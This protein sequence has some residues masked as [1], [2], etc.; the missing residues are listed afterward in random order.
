MW[1]E[2]IE[3]RKSIKSSSQYIVNLKWLPA[4]PEMVSSWLQGS[5]KKPQGCDY[6]EV[7]SVAM[8]T[9]VTDSSGVKAIDS[10]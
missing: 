4:L 3:F 7:A 10:Q 2:T 8:E 6:G 9:R 5:C 1:G